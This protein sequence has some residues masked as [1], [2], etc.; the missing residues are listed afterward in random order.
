MAAIALVFVSLLLL[1][2]IHKPEIRSAK[3]RLLHEWFFWTFLADCAI[4]TWIGQEPVEDPYILIGQ[5]AAVWFFLYLLIITPGI[6]WLEAIL[7]KNIVIN[8]TN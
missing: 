1:P 7:I 4:L 5:L 2:Y 6:A 3:F 8:K